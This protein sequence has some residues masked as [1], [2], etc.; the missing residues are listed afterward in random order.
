VP[1]IL[2]DFFAS[3][4]A[5]LGPVSRAIPLAKQR[6]G[7]NDGYLPRVV[8]SRFL[9]A[10]CFPLPGSL[11]PAMQHHGTVTEALAEYALSIPAEFTAVTAYVYAVPAATVVSV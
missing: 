6:V 8:I 2:Q 7:V 9:L 4:S 3:R 10:D 11:Q 5:G 1:G